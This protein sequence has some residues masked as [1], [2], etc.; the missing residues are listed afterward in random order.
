MNRKSV[1]VT[2]VTLVGNGLALCG[3]I[4][5]E[6]TIGSA[7]KAYV[8][9][10]Y[11]LG[12]NQLIAAARL[13]KIDVVERLLSNGDD[14]NAKDNDHRTSLHNAA[15]NGDKGMVKLLLVNKADVNARNKFNFATPLHW[16][17]GYGG[18]QDIVD[19]L[20][21]YKAEVNAR[22]KDG[23]TPLHMAAMM[24]GSKKSVH[25]VDIINVLLAK[26]ADVNAK[27]NNDKT[28]LAVAES[29]GHKDRAAIL[30]QHGGHE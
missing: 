11:S 28:P 23:R 27:D 25:Y 26:G 30:R 10:Y 22:D 19:M 29:A 3:E 2:L 4:H 6:A 12:E 5:K 1:A 14:V 16:A 21:S 8:G 20:L 17:A 7:N 13:G 9:A 18:N 15:T 24:D